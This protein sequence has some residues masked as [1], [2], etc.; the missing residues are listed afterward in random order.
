MPPTSQPFSFPFPPATK[1]PINNAKTERPT[2]S[3]VI[4]DSLRLV[5]FNNKEKTKLVAN[6]MIKMVTRP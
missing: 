3:Q 5:N 4:E 2:S 1:P 6:A